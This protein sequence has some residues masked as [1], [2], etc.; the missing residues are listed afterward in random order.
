MASLRARI[1]AFTVRRAVRPRLG[2]MRDIAKVR[3]VFDG[4]SFPDPPGVTYAPGSLGGISGEHVS[5]HKARPDAPRVLYLHGGGFVAC[6]ARTHRP[7][8]GA[9][10]RRGLNLFAPDYRLAPEHPFPAAIDDAVAAWTA[11]RAGGPAALAGDSAGGNLA[12]ALMLRLREAGLPMPEA[13]ALFS[14]ATDLVGTGL[15]HRA[16]AARDAMFDPEGLQQLVAAYL[17]AADPSDPLASPLL[18]DLT[19]LPPLLLHVGEREVLRDDSVRL[20]EK[21][22]AAGVPVVLSVFPV[23]P[24]AWQFAGHRVPESRR[25]LD[26][27]AGFLRAHLA[28]RGRT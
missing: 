24:H 21:A 7:V 19:G 10:A 28:A 17:G 4:A 22:K 11:F 2:D 25:S 9:L 5:A 20:A 16:N 6:S 14:P 18:A 26:Q 12:L 1:Y 27:A 3:R 13:A 8:T 23:V 15:S